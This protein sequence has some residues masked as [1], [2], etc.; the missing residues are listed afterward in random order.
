MRYGD[1]FTGAEWP[2]R[3]QQEQCTASLFATIA[4]SHNVAGASLR[5]SDMPPRTART[6]RPTCVSWRLPRH[7][8]QE[9]GLC[10]R[11]DC[12]A[13]WL[14]VSRRELG[15]RRALGAS[16]RDVVA[17]FA[18]KWTGVVGPAA[19]AGLVLQFALLRTIVSQLEAVQAASITHLARPQSRSMPQLL[20][21]RV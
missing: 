4:T 1:S 20:P 17:W 21:L 7:C 19:V 3:R 12:M 18:T 14:E 15:I 13:Y 16:H 10:W 11:R 9:S 8:W 6:P 2:G 5:A